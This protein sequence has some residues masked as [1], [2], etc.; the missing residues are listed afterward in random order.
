MK[1]MVFFMVTSFDK[2]TVLRHLL[3]TFEI[4]KIFLAKPL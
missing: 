4:A 1:Y 2:M 3:T